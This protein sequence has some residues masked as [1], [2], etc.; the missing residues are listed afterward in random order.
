M[1][2]TVIVNGVAGVRE[3]SKLN[4]TANT[5]ISEAQILENKFISNQ[6]ASGEIDI[7]LP[8]V[9]YPIEVI[10]SSEEAQTLE[11]GPPSGE[12]VCLDGA[13][14]HADDVVDS[15]DAVG[16]LM[17]CIRLQIADGSWIWNFLSTQGTWT[18]SGA[19]D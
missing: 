11:V 3:R 13:N 14:L 12:L 16:S 2:D 8:A 9:S 15:D 1:A 6:G 4:L 10:I 7:T 19:S 17:T 5:T 18:D